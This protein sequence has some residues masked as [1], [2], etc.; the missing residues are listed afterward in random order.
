MER[1]LTTQIIIKQS[2]TDKYFIT[3][4]SD[5][6]S[7]EIIRCESFQKAALRLAE[8]VGFKDAQL[9]GFLKLDFNGRNPHWSAIFLLQTESQEE[10]KFMLRTEEIHGEFLTLEEFTHKAAA[11]E[12]SLEDNS[13]YKWVKYLDEGGRVYPLD[14]IP[15]K[16]VRLRKKRKKH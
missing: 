4:Q 13:Q 1:F 9:E 15:H 10:C 7:A 5:L 8:E 14:I 3:N 6:L 2:G 16:D 11:E 12:A